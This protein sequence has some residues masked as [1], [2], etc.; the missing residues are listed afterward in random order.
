VKIGDVVHLPPTL[1]TREAAELFGVHHETLL[2]AVRDGTSPVAPLRIGRRMV[3][4]TTLVLDAVGL[5]GDSE[6]RGST[7][8][9]SPTTSLTDTAK[10]PGARGAA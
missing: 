8:D 6:G 2:A 9:P 5:S 3:W 7:P 1:S 10:A 4:P